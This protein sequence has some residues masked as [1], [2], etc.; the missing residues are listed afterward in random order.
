MVPGCP[1]HLWV[2]VRAQAQAQPPR[3]LGP[4]QAW[5]WGASLLGLNPKSFGVGL[6]DLIPSLSLWCPRLLHW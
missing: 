2:M 4:S 5:G 6:G 3:R 1:P